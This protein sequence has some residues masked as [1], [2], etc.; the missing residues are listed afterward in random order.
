MSNKII[1]TTILSFCIFILVVVNS[2]QENKEWKKIDLDEKNF[3]L[4]VKLPN[5]CEGVSYN[6]IGTKSGI[7]IV[8]A[9]F[10]GDNVNLGQLEK[11]LINQ[12]WVFKKKE[13]IDKNKKSFY[14]HFE[15]GEYIYQ[16]ISY[17]NGEW[18]EYIAKKR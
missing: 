12:G 8:A 5:Q 15:K 10:K 18:G 13:I 17:E 4:S 7:P 3:Y 6:K 1:I 2:F 11:Q 14:L 16:L 9:V